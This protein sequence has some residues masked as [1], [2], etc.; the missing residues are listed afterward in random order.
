VR[1]IEVLEKQGVCRVRPPLVNCVPCILFPIIFLFL[2]PQRE[3][4]KI[5]RKRKKKNP[6]P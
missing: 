5:K 4:R 2:R 1:R 3:E 6:A